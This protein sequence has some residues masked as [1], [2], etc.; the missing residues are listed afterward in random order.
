MRGSELEDLMAE[1]DPDKADSEAIERGINMI[2][3]KTIECDMTGMDYRWAFRKVKQLEGRMMDHSITKI[4]DG[5]KELTDLREV[6][7]VFTKT[8]A[9]QFKFEDGEPTLQGIPD[10]NSVEFGMPELERQISKT[11]EKK[12]PDHIW[13]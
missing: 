11:K 7:D 8:Y 6:A 10:D 2:K 5:E 1:T 3:Q 4:V 9:D 13:T 12:A